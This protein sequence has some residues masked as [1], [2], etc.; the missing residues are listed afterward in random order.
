MQ[1][2]TLDTIAVAIVAIVTGVQYLRGKDNFSQIVYESA[3]FCAAA[4]GANK[5]HVLVHEL[6]KFSLSVSFLLCFL[7]LA[8]LAVLFSALLNA[9]ASFDFGAFNYL[10]ALFVALTSAYAFGH[11]AMRVFEYGF[12]VGDPRL[13]EAM[14]R[15]WVARELIYFRTGKEVLAFLRFARWKD[16]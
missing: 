9:R 3:G 16:Q 1:Y 13:T 12:V 8:A 6:T 14:G 15:S 11:A 5:L 10:L 4:F 7:V 2:T